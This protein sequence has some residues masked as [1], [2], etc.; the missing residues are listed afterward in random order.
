[1][2]VIIRLDS[3]WLSWLVDNALYS[4]DEVLWL[5]QWLRRGAVAGVVITALSNGFWFFD[6][7][8]HLWVSVMGPIGAATPGFLYWFAGV[9]LS[10]FT[11]VINCLLVYGVLRGLAALLELL[12]QM[13]VNSRAD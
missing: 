5:S 1:M 11:I 4:P 3:T 13:E 8:C 7:Q 9:L 12:M 6:A 10:L 2:G